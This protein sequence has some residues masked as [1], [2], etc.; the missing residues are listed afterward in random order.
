MLNKNKIMKEKIMCECQKEIKLVLNKYNTCNTLDFVLAKYLENCL[1][2]FNDVITLKEKIDTEKLIDEIEEE[3]GGAFI[4]SN[5]SEL[6]SNNSESN[7]VTVFEIP[8]EKEINIFDDDEEMKYDTDD[9]ESNDSEVSDE[10]FW[11]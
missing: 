2:T 10:D 9:S 8:D 4:N 11:N 5:D 1:K 7:L 3:N 6:K